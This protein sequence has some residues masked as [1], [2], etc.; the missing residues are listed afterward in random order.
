MRIVRIFGF[1]SKVQI[2]EPESVKEQYKPMIATVNANEK[3]T[4][5]E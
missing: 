3:L 1:A 2:F 4:P 5:S